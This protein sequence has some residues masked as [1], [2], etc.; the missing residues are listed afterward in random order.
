[1]SP[2]SQQDDTSPSAP[3]LAAR[4]SD[5]HPWQPQQAPALASS[6]RSGPAAA[7]A[8]AVVLPVL[9]EQLGRTTALLLVVWFATALAYYGVVMLTTQLALTDAGGSRCQ[10]GA[11]HVP[12]SDLRAILIASAAEV[13]SLALS[14]AAMAALGHRGALGGC[15]LAAA[16]SIAALVPAGSTTALLF[17]S[18]LLTMASFTVLWVL[19][20]EYYPTPVRAF[21]LGLCNACSRLGACAAPLVAVWL[22]QLSGPAAAEACLAGACAVAAMA[23]AALRGTGQDLSVLSGG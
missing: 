2:E 3:L 9:S 23:V 13:P 18:R 22:L 10:G 4:P 8:A 17:C 6:S 16:A 12:A 7:P 14:A 1:M 19:T 15:L 20:P 21:G 5:Q 11:V